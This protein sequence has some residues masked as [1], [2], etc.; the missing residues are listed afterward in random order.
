M[1]TERAFLAIEPGNAFV[2]WFKPILE[3]LNNQY[4]KVRWVRFQ[5]LHLTLRFLCDVE[6]HSLARILQIME[7]S[8]SKVSPTPESGRL[9]LEIE[10]P[11]CFGRKNCPRVFW[12]GLK[13]NL[14]LD[15]II[16]ILQLNIFKNE[17]PRNPQIIPELLRRKGPQSLALE[18]CHSPR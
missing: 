9:S 3:R 13:S 17:L 2:D 1:V 15:L 5:N 14:H 7:D 16:W 10:G 18:L 12:L 11:G 8:I 6:T 4:P